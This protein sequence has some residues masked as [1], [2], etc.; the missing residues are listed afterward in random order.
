MRT[1]TMFLLVALA[2]FLLFVPDAAS[3]AESRTGDSILVEPGEVVAG[4]LYVFGRSVEINGTVEGDLVGTVESIIVRGTI[5]GSLNIAARSIQINGTIARTARVAGETLIVRG[6]IQGDLVSAVSELTLTSAGSIGED[7][8]LA[9]GSATLSGAVNGDITGSAGEL[10]LGGAVGGDVEV[11][12][13]EINVTNRGRVAGDLRYASGAEVDFLGQG[14]VAGTVEQTGS[15]RALG[16]PNVFTSATSLIVRVLIGLV[17]GLVLITLF[18]S[19]VV[20]TADAI[21]VELPSSVFSGILG[22]ILWSV[23]AILLSVLIVGIPI[24]VV[25]TVVLL[26]IAWLSQVFVGVALG[27]WIMPKNWHVTSRGYN[28]LAMAI[29]MILIGAVRAA[30]VPY[31]SGLIAIVS[32]ILAIGAV[33]TVLRAQPEQSW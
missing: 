20:R 17:S 29:G 14:A 5:S 15:I 4:D 32:A 9:T 1:C 21:R 30:P 10:N 26:F 7:L 8:I 6:T 11:T 27:R 19:A 12:A 23:M 33:V 2:S 18:P 3:A 22:T 28:I 31:V 13:D 16:G 25:G 24:A